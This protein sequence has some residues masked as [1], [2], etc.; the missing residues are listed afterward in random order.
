M[1]TSIPMEVG[2][3]VWLSRWVSKSSKDM[4]IIKNGGISTPI[5]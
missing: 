5:P 1:E 4:N 3:V 2:M